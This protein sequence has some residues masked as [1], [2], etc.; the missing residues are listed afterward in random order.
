MVFGSGPAVVGS[1][2]VSS[3]PLGFCLGAVLHEPVWGH[4]R[5]RSG[6]PLSRVV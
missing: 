4:L 2:L 3:G 5:I 6:T 1:I